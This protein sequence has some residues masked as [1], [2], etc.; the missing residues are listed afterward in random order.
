MREV[1]SLPCAHA[2]MTPPV[3][4][5]WHTTE[6]KFSPDKRACNK[7]T[8]GRL[9]DTRDTRDLLNTLVSVIKRATGCHRKRQA[10]VSTAAP[11]PL[12][13]VGQSGAAG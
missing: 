6:L 13:R 12:P 11:V 8:D 10:T 9:G 3:S 1:Q 2:A 4:H 7:R 5:A